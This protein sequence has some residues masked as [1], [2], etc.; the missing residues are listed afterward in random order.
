MRRGELVGLEVTDIDSDLDVAVMLGKGRRQR[1]A[2][3]TNGPHSRSTAISAPAF[4]I[5][6]PS[7]RICGSRGRAPWDRAASASS[8][9]ALR[10][11]AGLG[12]IHPH[13]FRHMVAP[14]DFRLTRG[15]SGIL[16]QPDDPV[17]L[18]KPV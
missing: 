2:P 18:D 8:G 16:L 14:R 17:P 4:V 10:P 11:Q 7:C 9:S 1:Q 13:Q 6:M 5:A 12:H 15:S 3:S